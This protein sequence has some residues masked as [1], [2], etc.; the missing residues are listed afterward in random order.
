MP[1]ARV[2][3]ARPLL[4]LRHRG[5]AGEGGG[6][7]GAVGLGGRALAAGGRHEHGVGLEAGV[8]VGGGGDGQ[9]EEEEEGEDDLPDKGLRGAER[10]DEEAEVA[11]CKFI[12]VRK[13]GGDFF[14][15]DGLVDE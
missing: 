9:E 14:G 13:E 7:R 6:P 8:G 1:Q 12:Q 4:Y 15:V 10:R 11:R 5:G 3:P 2:T